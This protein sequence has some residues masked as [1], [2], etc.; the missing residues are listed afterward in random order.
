[1]RTG[2]VLGLMTGTA[3]LA[4]RNYRS[5]PVLR[6]TPNAPSELVAIVVPARNEAARLPALLAS[7]R[8]LEGV[9]Y[10]VT[11]VDDG[12]E[13]A[14]AQV[15]RA[16]GAEVIHLEGPP[17]GWT[18]KAFACMVGAGQTRGEW[19][20]FTDADTEHGPDSLRWALGEAVQRDAGLLSLLPR[21]VCR[22]FPERLL[23]PYAYAL[24]FVGAGRANRPGGPA[25]ANGQYMLFRRAVYERVGGHGVVRDSLIEDVALAKVL[26][27]AGERVVLLRGESAVRVRMYDGL[28]ALWEGFSKNAFRFVQAAPRRGIYTAL[29]SVVLSSALPAA[30][31]AR[32]GPMRL[33]L[34]GA[35]AAALV[36]WVRRFGVPLPYAGLAPLA[37]LTFQALALDSMRR[38]AVRGATVWKGRRY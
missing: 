15:A 28:G 29:A 36:P 22:T 7:L 16:G 17:P 25:V 11:V 12:S 26:R 9:E 38:A 31:A 37:A 23:L 30:L 20:L 13:D 18:G 2:A 33:I 10:T 3:V 34:L 4:E 5:I 35:P 27:E 21:Q 14:T 32:S 19:I 6:A 24:Y 8:T 1:M